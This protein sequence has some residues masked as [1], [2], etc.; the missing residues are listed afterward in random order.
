MPIATTYTTSSNI[1]WILAALSQMA[2]ITTDKT[3]VNIVGTSAIDPGVTAPGA[4]RTW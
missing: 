2:Y 3:N 1:I 4:A